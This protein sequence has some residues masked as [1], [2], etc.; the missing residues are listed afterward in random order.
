[1]KAQIHLTVEEDSRLLRNE[2]N[3]NADVNMQEPEKTGVRE[4]SILNSIN[5][6]HV[7]INYIID[8]MYDIMEGVANYV[9]TD[10]ITTYQKRLLYNWLIKF[11]NKKVSFW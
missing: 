4:R 5:N 11:S 6:F 3:Y 2:R 7:C 9:M 10:L 1:M 8:L